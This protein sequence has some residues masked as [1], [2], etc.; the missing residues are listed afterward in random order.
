M[1]NNITNELKHVVQLFNE[2]IT[3]VANNL[4]QEI[5]KSV[6]LADNCG[7][8]FY[9]S[10]NISDEQIQRILCQIPLTKETDY[11]FHKTKKILFYQL[12]EKD[13]R[14]IV[15][16]H[17]IQQE[18][19]LAVIQKIR[20][21]SLAFKTYLDMQEQ[22]KKQAKV[23]E[24]KL[25]ET[26]VKSSANIY[27]IIGLY[28]IDLQA[29]Q[30][31]RILLWDVD[32]AENVDELMAVLGDFCTQTVGR[33][34]APPILWNDTIVVI[35]SA[36]YNQ[37]N[38]T[39]DIQKTAAFWQTRLEA[40]FGIKLG[41]GIGR[42]YMLSKLHKSYIEAKIALILPGVLGKCGQVQKFDDLGVYSMV[43]SHEVSSLKEY[44]KKT[45][46]PVILY[47]KEVNMQLIDTLRILLRNDFNWAKT[48]KT[49]F[50]HVNT[51]YYRYDK[52][53]KM[54]NFDLS[55]GKDRSEVFAALIVWD[56]LSKMG[57]IGE[58]F[59]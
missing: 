17:C 58:D 45:L 2:G 42:T 30:Y 9:S 33:K 48:A 32:P 4:E 51:I 57:F 27:D 14:L 31:Y 56:V 26:L 22:L 3:R 55:T 18:E 21:R 24:K 19:I 53:E 46:G 37:D 47:D 28:N 49:M 20:V 50:A 25:V 54:I 44:V 1:E 59:L 8:I 36:P 43:F 39:D 38:L 12:S 35:L 15:G 52:I 10:R 16:I 13:R 29:D 23:F 5:E 34:I 41:C 7:K 6:L 40:D 11:Y